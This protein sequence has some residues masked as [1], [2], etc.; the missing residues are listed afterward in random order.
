MKNV[1]VVGAGASGIMAA[2]TAA[3]EGCCVTVLEQ[4]EKPLKKLLLTGNGRCNLTNLD[5]R[6]D[7]LRGSNVKKA[8]EIESR[9]NC[10]DVIWFFRD[11]GMLIKSRSDWVYPVTDSAASVAKLLLYE[12]DRL[13]IKIKTNQTVTDIQKTDGKF[14]VTTSDWKYDADSVIISVGS[15]AGIER[16]HDEKDGCL[17][18][19]EVAGKFG[20]PSRDFLP[21]ITALKSSEKGIGAWAGVR[22]DGVV[23]LDINKNTFRGC[24]GQLQLT[25]YGISGIPIFQFSRYAV[26]ALER[27]DGVRLRLDFLPQM[28]KDRLIRFLNYMAQ[29]R[30][31]WSLKMILS[32]ILNEKLAGFIAAQCNDVEEAV[33]KIKGYRLPIDGY[34]PVE[35]AQACMGGVDLNALTENLEA[36]NCKGLYFTGEAVDVDGPCGGYNLQWAW[37]SGHAAGTA[38]A[39]SH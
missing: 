12:A 34:L 7:C 2:I 13:K 24:G 28:K 33:H 17:I 14:D 30:P 27:G 29:R 37:S 21:A 32:G 22:V 9:F 38:C 5:W 10:D 19:N 4:N 31:E 36:K 3:R 39:A 23:T 35:R 15:P 18:G 11:L 6:Y 26:D 1:I 25:E 8:E 16:G 20:I